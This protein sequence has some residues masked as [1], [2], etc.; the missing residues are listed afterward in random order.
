MNLA[1]AA[2]LCA[3]AVKKTARCHGL[4]IVVE[5]PR[6]TIRE[7]KNDAGKVV[8]RKHMF[9]D[10]GYLK[11]TKGRDGDGVDCFLGPVGDKAKEVYI[12]HMK[13]L[14]PDKDEREDEDKVMLGFP[15]YE[16]AR[17]AFIQ[18]YPESF[19][20]SMSAMPVKLFVKRMRTASKPW[21]E[22]K[23]HAYA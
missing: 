19:L 20:E 16:A 9:A 15:S 2:S 12:A 5:A 18:H 21:R 6:G 13:D 22:K 14:G 23:I 3:L 17:Q 4:P 11:G 8:Y 1:A 10:Y 7:L